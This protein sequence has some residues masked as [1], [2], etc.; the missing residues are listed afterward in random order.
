[1]K[2]PMADQEC[3]RQLALNQTD[4]LEPSPLIATRRDKED[5]CEDVARSCHRGIEQT[6]TL[7]CPLCQCGEQRECGPHKDVADAEISSC[8]ERC[9]LRLGTPA[10]TRIHENHWHRRG[11][12]HADHH[13]GPHCKYERK[14]D[15]RPRCVSRH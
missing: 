4:V 9:A 5:S 10:H 6:G 3:K 8:A 1:M 12:H 13:H 11:Y 7:K 2:A 14:L 15:W